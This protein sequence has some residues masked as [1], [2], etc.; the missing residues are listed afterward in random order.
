VG[1]YEFNDESL[2][3]NHTSGPSAMEV[4]LPVDDD[5]WGIRR[6]FWAS[7]D[8][9]Y[10]SAARHFEKNKQTLKE[11]GKKLEEIPHRR[12]AKVQP[13][14]IIQ[15][16]TPATYS[17]TQWE[18]RMRKLSSVFS[19]EPTIMNSFAFVTYSEGYKYL[20]STEGLVAKIPF[21]QA[22][23]VLGVQVKNAEG[24]FSA[25]REVYKAKTLDQLPSDEQLMKDINRMIKQIEYAREV[26]EL[27]EEYSGPILLEGKAVAEAFA[28]SILRGREGIFAN[29]NIAKLKGFQFDDELLSAEGKIGKNV[30]NNQITIKAKPRLTKYD[31]VD[32]TGHFILDN[33]GVSPP[34]ELTIIEKGV[35]RNLLNNRTLTTA[36]QTANGFSSSPGV[37][38]VT[39]AQAT[40]DKVL[41]E[42]LLQQAKNEGLAFALIF[43]EGASP[44]GFVDAFKVF[45]E[46]GREEPVKNVSLREGGFKMW[47]RILGA[48][49]KYSAF[50]LDDAIFERNFQQ[51]TLSMIVPQAILLEEVEVQP[52]RMPSLKEE[53]YISRPVK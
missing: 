5:Y 48:S 18:Q 14:K 37:L 25:E 41:K 38:E 11:S 7:T 28:S 50:N 17:R 16:L 36:T 44:M 3:D 15:T 23:L 13:M 52:F 21:S 40:T 45:V 1:D 10:R 8:N 46:D 32:L 33:E 31:G 35:L 34:E 51:S 27:E 2:D 47:K 39:V 12:F 19:T 53:E 6:S 30:I 26:K 4:A 42:K 9:V 29:D 22:S 43:R 20:V 24:K 49:E